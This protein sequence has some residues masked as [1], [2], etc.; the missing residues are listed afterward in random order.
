MKI[1][2]ISI[3]IPIY[4]V[5]KYLNKCIDSIVNQSYT[6]FELLLINDGSTDKSG[7]IC[8]NYA[9]IDP[10]IKVIH[11]ENAKMATARNA[12]LKIANGE[13]IWFIDSDDWIEKDSVQHIVSNMI[14]SDLEI[15]GFAFNYYF[16]KTNTFSKSQNTYKI[17]QCDSKNYIKQETF[18]SPLIWSFVYRKDFL[19]QNNI[20]FIETILHEDEAF[21]LHCFSK[22]KQI[23]KSDKV[24]YNYRQR[25]NSFMSSKPSEMRIKSFY[26]LVKM[27]KEFKNNE[28]EPEFLT[29][30][31]YNLISILFTFLARFEYEKSLKNEIIKQI[32]EL[33]PKQF[34]LKSD[35]NGIK[36]EKRVYNLNPNLYLLL[37]KIRSN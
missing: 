21:N 3:I 29:R 36:I 32:S 24:L 31:I 14:D 2:T 22:L 33:E 9:K 18:L 27:C 34:I 6:D 37:K 26:V 25:E 16:E 20:T 15:F 10:R 35:A 28:F 1:P 30:K 8:N 17:E 13:L 12:G 4:N 7:E 11:Q 23:K 19:N 5:E